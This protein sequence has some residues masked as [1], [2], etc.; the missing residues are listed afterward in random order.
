MS[1]V[2]GAPGWG[3][4]DGSPTGT[5]VNVVAASAPLWEGPQDEAPMPEDAQQ[6]KFT[7]D[8]DRNRMQCKRDA[9]FATGQAR[10]NAELVNKV[11]DANKNCSLLV[12][13]AYFRNDHGRAAVAVGNMETAEYVA[14]L[15]PGMG[16][17]L[18]SLGELVGHARNLREQCIE[19][20]PD[21]RVAVVAWVGYKA[22][23]LMKV[24]FEKPAA[25]GGELLLRDLDTWRGHWCKSA[26][27]KKRNLEDCPLLTVSGLSYG[28]VVTGHAAHAAVQD[29]W[30]K[31]VVDNLAFLGSAGTGLRAGH[32]GGSEIY[33]AATASDPVSWLNHFSID[34]AHKNYAE[35]HPATRMRVKYHWTPAKDLT[36]PFTS[37][38]SYYKPGSESLTNLS[39]VVV[40]RGAD[41]SR[42]AP[43]TGLIVGHRWT[44]ANLSKTPDPAPENSEA[45][46]R[47]KRHIMSTLIITGNGDK[48]VEY[49]SQMM[50]G[51]Q[52]HLRV[53][54]V[55]SQFWHVPYGQ[56]LGGL[57]RGE[58]GTMTAGQ[59]LMSDISSYYGP[60]LPPDAPAWIGPIAAFLSYPSTETGAHDAPKSMQDL[61]GKGKALL[62]LAKHPKA[63]GQLMKT[64]RA[65]NPGADYFIY[66]AALTLDPA[67]EANTKLVKTLQQK[68]GKGDSFSPDDFYGE[69]GGKSYKELQDVGYIERGELSTFQRWLEDVPG[70]PVFTYALN[71]LSGSVYEAVEMLAEP[72]A[73]GC[74]KVR[75]WF[76]STLNGG[77]TDGRAATYRTFLKFMISLYQVP[78][79]YDDLMVMSD[80]DSV[81]GKEIRNLIEEMKKLTNEVVAAKEA[82]TDAK[83]D[84]IQRAGQMPAFGFVEEGA[85]NTREWFYGKFR[86]LTGGVFHDITPMSYPAY[87]ERILNEQLV[88][89]AAMRHF[90]VARQRTMQKYL[91]KQKK[92]HVVA[93]L[94]ALPAAWAGKAY[95]N[96]KFKS[97]DALLENFARRAD[98]QW[99]YLTAK[100]QK[101]KDKLRLVP[102]FKVRMSSY[103]YESDL[104]DVAVRAANNLWTSNE[105]Q[106]R[107]LAAAGS[108]A[109]TQPQ[110]PVQSRTVASGPKWHRRAWRVEVDTDELTFVDF[111]TGS[112]ASW[113]QVWNEAPLSGMRVKA[114]ERVE[115]RL[116]INE[117]QNPREADMVSSITGKECWLNAR[118]QFHVDIA[119][120]SGKS[121]EVEYT[122]GVAPGYELLVYEGWDHVRTVASQP[123]ANPREV[124]KSTNGKPLRLRLRRKATRSS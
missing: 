107:R 124:Y 37:H 123:M 15:V 94:A 89:V 38:Q 71:R 11:L 87:Y 19:T 30:G 109:Q 121:G 55:P 84:R 115:G 72:I 25:R 20:R 113:Q 52:G 99:S 21:S 104:T 42:T 47:Q 16:S 114:E 83:N 56:A 6:D 103:K 54:R 7:A 18:R 58:A 116:H 8:S 41:V 39:R 49:A 101:E 4:A 46:I 96:G 34:P 88:A 78:G 63:P 5:A 95:K 1:V 29:D 93:M 70:L 81:E 105:V 80:P 106:A 62:D 65:L 53:P 111:K 28:S 75:E 35:K 31:P 17:S 79:A 50:A 57:P 61:K 92:G 33:T 112:S 85:Q 40:D 108:V 98:R 97:M 86:T 9:N 14:V 73:Y 23:G 60:S 102:E 66:L 64:I 82:S 48:A 27:R 119:P 91:G 77:R 45:R 69:V 100:T 22:P 36:H 26:V 59:W 43:R 120:K 90:P 122:I 118:R 10:S 13:D 68:S 67:F 32:L 2:T 74:L 3:G 76:D 12:Y 24:A 110:A 44:P 51:L 117:N